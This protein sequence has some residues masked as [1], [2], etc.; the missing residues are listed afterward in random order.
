M[1]KTTI[2]SI[3]GKD[4]KNKRVD[5]PAFEKV[6]GNLGYN[7]GIY[8]DK[9]VATR[10]IGLDRYHMF[11][12]STQ[13]GFIYQGSSVYFHKDMRLIDGSLHKTKKDGIEINEELRRIREYMSKNIK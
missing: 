5:R 4:N 2:S 13:D 11:I 3:M 7:V 6:L 8:G 9:I 1:V 10:Y 12:H